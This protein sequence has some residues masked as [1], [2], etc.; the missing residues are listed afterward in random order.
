MALRNVIGQ[1]KASNILLRTLEKE[2][3]PSAYLFAGESGVGKKYTALNLAKALNC[4]NKCYASSGG[5]QEIKGKGPLPGAQDGLRVDACDMCASCERISS[6]THPDLVMVAPEKGEIRVAEVR[7]IEEALSFK[8]FEGRKKVVIMDDADSMN[9][10]A[11]NAF[12][13]TLEEPPEESL[14][15]LITAHPER[16]PETIRSRCCRINF[17]PLSPEACEEVIRRSLPVDMNVAEDA[18]RRISLLVRL[19]MGRP[20][21]A[22]SLDMEKERERFLG[23]LQNMLQ[24]D[25]ETWADREAMEQWIDMSLLFLRDMTVL[26]VMEGQPTGNFSGYQDGDDDAFLLNPDMK[27]IVS[28]MVKR[29]DI[30]RIINIYGKMVSLKGQIGFN[31]NKAITWNYTAYIMR[32]MKGNE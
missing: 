15:I 22:V 1:D 12:L 26:K 25:G 3:V 10:S 32:S 5:G 24:G 20:G 7:E 6:M 19:S 30:S 9:Q 21:L 16:L 31:L 8:P 2:R 28:K 29:V 18:Q 17:V 27:N 23:F 11:A 4:P 13:K 14:L